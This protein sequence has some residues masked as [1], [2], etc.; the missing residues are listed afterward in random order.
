MALSCEIRRAVEEDERAA[1]AGNQQLA[2]VQG[3]PSKAYEVVGR[4]EF[5]SGMRASTWGQ[6]DQRGKLKER[7]A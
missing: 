5:L 1:L 4:L 2:S 3:I 7:G 6:A